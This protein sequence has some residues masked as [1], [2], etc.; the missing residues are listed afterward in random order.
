MEI[1]WLIYFPNG[2]NQGKYVNYNVSFRDRKKGTSQ[3]ETQSCLGEILERTEIN[4]N[5]PHTIGYYKESSGEGASFRPEYLEIRIIRTVEDF[6]AFL[7][8]LDI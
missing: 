7:N 6:W 2:G 3:Q 4:D 5:Y 8:S 1:D